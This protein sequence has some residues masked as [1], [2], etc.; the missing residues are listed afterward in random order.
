MVRA[1]ASLK[2]ETVH[3]SKTQFSEFQDDETEGAAS[4]DSSSQHDDG[5]S[6]TSSSII[7]RTQMN[8]HLHGRPPPPVTLN[9]AILARRGQAPSERCSA[10]TVTH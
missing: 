1:L 4:S 3:W 2:V 7:T 9:I 6:P 10:G 5:L 8:K